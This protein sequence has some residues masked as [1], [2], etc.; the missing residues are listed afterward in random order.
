MNKERAKK[1]EAAIT[2]LEEAAKAIRDIN[3][4]EIVGQLSS[5]KEAIEGVQTE[6][7]EAFDDMSEKSQE[8][9]KGQRMS[10]IIDALG[11]VTSEIDD[12][13]GELNDC[14]WGDALDEF[15]GKIK[16]NME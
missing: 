16:E 15:V 11:E 6:E 9:E 1:L 3:I 8:G 7:Q 14:S 13:I 12:L 5:A 2:T 4:D 10:E